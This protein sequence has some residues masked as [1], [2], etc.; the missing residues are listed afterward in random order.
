MRADEVSIYKRPLQ[1]GDLHSLPRLK[2]SAA[3]WIV[4]RNSP[5]TSNSA[6]SLSFSQPSIKYSIVIRFCQPTIHMAAAVSTRSTA[7]QF[8][9]LVVGIA[10]CLSC[11]ATPVVH[12]QYNTC[13][14]YHIS[15]EEQQQI[16]D[17][18]NLLRS[19]VYPYASNMRRMVCG[20]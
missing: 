15:Y 11:L 2:A 12:S 6:L 20:I 14:T 13:P 3:L 1:Q 10:I 19:K 4:R 8:P 9:L 5:S 18:H 17:R 16:V 7:M